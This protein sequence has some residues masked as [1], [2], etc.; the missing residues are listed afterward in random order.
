MQATGYLTVMAEA[1]GRRAVVGL[2]TLQFLAGILE[3]A[4]LA[5]LL[6]VI[7]VLS[8]AGEL[9]LPVVG[10]PVPAWAAVLVVLFVLTLRA[11]AQWAVAVRGFHLQAVTADMVSLGVLEELFHAR[12]SFIAAQRRSHLVQNVTTETHR[13]ENAIFLVI[14]LIVG[15]LTL[16]ATDE[17]E[18][19]LSPGVGIAGTV[20][21]LLVVVVA[22]R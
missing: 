1:C 22:R 11:L 14:R 3:A 16:L 7:Q 20:S 6:P 17:V 2:L 13:A 5:L 10:T 15:S 4:A 9:D 19:W 8:G 18:I 21:F 12:W